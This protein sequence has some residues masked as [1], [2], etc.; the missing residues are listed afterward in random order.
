MIVP[1]TAPM[2]RRLARQPLAWIVLGVLVAGGAF[3]LYWFTPWKLFTSH[4][5]NDSLPSAAAPGGGPSISV[6]PSVVGNTLLATGTLISHEH[7][8]TGTVSLIRLSSGAVQ[9]VLANLDTSDG[10]DLRVWL[11]D[12]AVQATSDGWHVFDDGRYVEVG[13]LKGNKGNQVYDVPQGTNL[14]GLTSVTIWCA[15]FKVS[16][17]AAQLHPAG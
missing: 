6:S 16:F 8:T 17:G 3:G 4:T 5:V 12:Q 13:R 10:P 11:T 7:H 1:K 9:L 14:D 15:R 2:L